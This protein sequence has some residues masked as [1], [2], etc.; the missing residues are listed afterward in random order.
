[1]KGYGWTPKVFSDLYHVPIRIQPT[2]FF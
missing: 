1:M 2:R